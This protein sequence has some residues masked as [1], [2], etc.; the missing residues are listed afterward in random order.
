MA[1]KPINKKQLERGTKEEMEH[2]ETIKKYMKKGV[3]VKEVAR[4]IARDHI[5][6]DP[7][8]YKE[9]KTKKKKK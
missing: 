7:N 2:S 4:S 5:K 9:N 6:I 1:S 3:S 8:A